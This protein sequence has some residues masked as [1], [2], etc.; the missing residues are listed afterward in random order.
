MLNNFHWYRVYKGGIWYYYRTIVNLQTIEF[1]SQK[2][3]PYGNCLFSNNY[4][5]LKR[6]YCSLIRYTLEKY[7]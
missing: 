5:E 3:L 6:K 2:K 7:L 4:E 1:W